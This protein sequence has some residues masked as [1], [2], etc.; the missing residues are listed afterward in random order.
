MK[1]NEMK[2]EDIK[3]RNFKPVIAGYCDYLEGYHWVFEFSNGYGAS[4]VCNEVSYGHND[5][6][7]ELAVIKGGDICYDTP[8]TNDVVGYL[9]ADEVADYLAEIRDL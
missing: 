4:V 5:G 8:V 9:T 3:F 7:F 2:F 1:F 6:L